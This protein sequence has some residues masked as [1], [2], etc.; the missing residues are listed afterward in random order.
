M[1]KIGVYYAESKPIAASV[2]EQAI[3][4]IEHSGAK[5]VCVTELDAAPIDELS[6]LL[7]IG[8]DGTILCAIACSYTYCITFLIRILE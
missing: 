6:A 2:A 1:E 7:A 3:R 4:V 5:A 8:G